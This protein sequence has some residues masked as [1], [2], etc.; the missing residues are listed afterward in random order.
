[1]LAA[2]AMIQLRDTLL[3]KLREQ[4]HL[5]QSRAV[6]GT[7]PL[8]PADD[9][10]ILYSMIGTKVLLPY[11]VAI[12]SLHQHLRRGRIVILDDGTLTPADKAV[13]AYHLGDPEIRHIAEVDLGPCPRGCVWERLLLLLELRK[14]AYVI[15]VDS[16]T[17]T[18]GPVPE[19]AAA[20]DQGCNFTLK[21]E[22]SARWLPVDDFVKTTPG[23]DPFSPETHVQGAT[24]EILPQIHAGLPQPS[25][26]VRG[27]AGFAGFA[28]GGLGRKSAEDFSR[29]AEAILGHESW[30][31]WG[32]EQV[33]SNVI[34]ANEGEP[35]LLPYDRY[36]NFWNEQLPADTRFAHFIGTYRFHLGAYAEATRR[37]IAALKG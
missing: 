22:D 7:A 18:L 11:L 5:R 16:D 31:R 19:V 21:G 29:E 27:C 24:E 28:P 35:V 36:L 2:P 15:Q 9:G 23:F 10:V 1:M 13:L 20:I 32:S 3:R 6:L 37:A 12:K 25:Y 33:M 4:L 26:Y 30:K 8:L 34:V 14:D 17:V